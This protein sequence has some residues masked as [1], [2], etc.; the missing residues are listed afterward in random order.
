MAIH[1]Q[2]DGCGTK[3]PKIRPDPEQ[4]SVPFLGENIKNR[5]YI[6]S[7]SNLFP[8]LLPHPILMSAIIFLDEAR[9]DR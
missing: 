9:I 7:V 4:E 2:I 6:T 5:N 3:P 1:Q 8:I